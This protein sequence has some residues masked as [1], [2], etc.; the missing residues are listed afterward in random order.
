LLG[1]TDVIEAGNCTHNCDVFT[2]ANAW[3]R[4]PVP[5]LVRQ[6]RTY[7]LWRDA[8]LEPRRQRCVPQITCLAEGIK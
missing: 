1:A 3:A 5:E 8:G 6:Q 4:A 7:V 2:A